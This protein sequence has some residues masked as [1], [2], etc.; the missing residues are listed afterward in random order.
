MPAANHN[1]TIEQGSAFEIVFEFINNNNL[2]I[3]LT[4]WCAILQWI[5]DQDNTEIF[6]TNY[7]GDDYRM[8]VDSLGK[9]TLQIP[10][11]ITKDYNF[12]SA[13]CYDWFFSIYTNCSINLFKLF[14]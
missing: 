6:N 8:F 12:D 7:D 13:I 4:N 9:I 2:P 11:K 10:A 5:D 14:Y 3:D 1:I